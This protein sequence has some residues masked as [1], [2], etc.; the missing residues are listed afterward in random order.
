MLLTLFS[1]L[2]WASPQRTL[3]VELE[4]SLEQLKGASEPVHYLGLALRETEA[5]RMSATS[6]ALNV[7]RNIRTRSL[8]VDLRVGTPDLDSTHALRGFSSFGE[9]TRETV[10]VPLGDDEM[11]AHAVWREV[12]RAYRAAAEAIVMVRSEATVKVEEESLAPD[13]EPRS[14]VVHTG[15]LAPLQVDEDLWAA[16]LIRLSQR[17]DAHPQIVQSNAALEARVDGDIFVDSEGSRIVHGRARYGLTLYVQA[18]ADDGDELTLVKTVEA[19]DFRRLPDERA[20]EAEADRLVAEVV[21]LRAAPRATPYVGPVVL[22]G[23]ATAVFFH[24]IFGHRVEGHRQRSEEE[25]KTFA[26]YLGRAVLPEFVDIVDDPTQSQWGEVDLSG[27]YAFD[28]EGVPAERVSLVENGIFNGFLMGRTPI[29]GFAHSNGHGRRSPGNAPTSRMGNTLVLARGGVSEAALEARLKAEIR[30][31]GLPYGYWVD[32][33]DGGFTLTGRMSP[34]SFKVGA[35]TMWRVFP[36]DRPRELVRGLDLVGTPLTAFQS[37]LAVSDNTEV[38]NG[39]CGA[40]SGWVPVS[41]VAPTMLFSRLELQ[42]KEKSQEKPPL[43]SKPEER[44]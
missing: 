24:E 5:V 32:D 16:R 26:S 21:A 2:L 14:A 7:A 17:L 31:A 10:Y 35:L 23:R 36:D 3:E 33:I 9:N 20:L 41:A 22:S 18:V 38:F 39:R 37:V 4:R 34:N 40:E 11:L 42:L 1:A 30:A 44:P 15:T 28:D 12:D 6:G 29:P 43:L 8:D 19:A 27:T 25:G 13:F